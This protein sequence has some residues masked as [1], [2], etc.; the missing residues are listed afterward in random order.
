MCPTYHV[1]TCGILKY[2]LLGI[3]DGRLH[4][5]EIIKD[6]LLLLLDVFCLNSQLLLDLL[7]RHLLLLSLLLV[8]HLHTHLHKETMTIGSERASKDEAQSSTPNLVE[9]RYN[10]RVF[11]EQVQR[12]LQHE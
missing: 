11:E 9:E 10:E 4:L 1:C 3:F 8:F 5:A 12:E 6:N 7:G 2:T